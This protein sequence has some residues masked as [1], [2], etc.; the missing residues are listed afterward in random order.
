MVILKELA[1]GF[2]LLHVAKQNYFKDIMRKIKLISS[3][4]KINFLSEINKIT[5]KG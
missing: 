1:I 5:I 2:E 3:I 4:N